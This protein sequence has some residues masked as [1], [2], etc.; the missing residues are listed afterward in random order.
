MSATSE[1]PPL[2]P[3]AE[4]AG[5]LAP[6]AVLEPQEQE[7]QTAR[8]AFLSPEQSKSSGVLLLVTMALFALSMQQGANTWKDIALLVAVVLFH[9]L[10]HWLG[11][12]LFG[13]QDVKMFFIPFMGAAVSGRNTGAV[14]WKEALVLLMGPMPGLV[15]GFALLVRTAVEP[16][17]LMSS[18][19]VLLVSLNAFNL[20]PL[21]PLDGGKLFQLLLF[22]RNRYLEILFTAFAGLTLLGMALLSGTWVLG[23]VAGFLLLSIPRQRKV[24]NA[25]LALRAA[26]P[27]SLREPAALGEPSLR[28]LYAAAEDLVPQ[29]GK[30]DQALAHRVRA[31]RDVHHRVRLRPPS[32]LA[33]LGLLVLWGIGAM[34]AVASLV[35]LSLE[36]APKAARWGTF[37]DTE[38]N[39]SV[40]MPTQEPPREAISYGAL[41][42]SQAEGATRHARLAADHEYS[43]TYWKVDKEFLTASEHERLFQDTRDAL[44]KQAELGGN[45]PKRDTEWKL[46]GV[47]GRHLSFSGPSSV[48]E[49]TV[50]EE[51]WFG[52]YYGRGYILRAKHDNRLANPEDVE[53]FFSS[54]QP[55]NSLEF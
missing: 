27:E 48:G 33:S 38:G 26:D 49:G 37:T 21:T 42:G 1:V 29:Q 55:L 36:M 40:L 54:F 20:L 12:R 9:E 22:S 16:S 14:A 32:V 34:V 43:V 53:R 31:M 39:Y 44:L 8:A 11:M 3:A 17:P 10:G 5:A 35:V 23:I 13:F 52:V 7:Y 47:Q 46:N 6:V 25:A 4:A 24:L 19:G 15:L 28:S 41:A 30:P 51:Y 45:G 2:A 50:L 18:V